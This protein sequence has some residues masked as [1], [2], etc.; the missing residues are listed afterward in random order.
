MRFIEI[1]KNTLLLL[2][3]NVTMFI[4]S[5]I[6]I[7]Y[8]Y[9]FNLIFS[10]WG[11]DSEFFNFYQLFT[12]Q[13]VHVD[14]KHLFFNMVFF[15]VLSSRVEQ[16]I[17]SSRI[18]SYYLFFGVLGALFHLFINPDSLPLVGASGSVWGFLILNILI[19]DSLPFISSFNR[20][21]LICL[22]ILEVFLAI[23]NKQDN[24]AHWCHLGGAFAGLIIWTFDTRLLQEK[25]SRST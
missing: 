11:T 13:F 5:S 4:I 17:G 8:Y 3:I 21:I 22:L 1:H 7:Q 6:M 19:K 20:M 10:V 16:E 18:I 23:D 2:M 9:F 24:V 25:I 14:F 12:Y 15:L